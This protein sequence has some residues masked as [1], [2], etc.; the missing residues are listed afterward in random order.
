MGAAISNQVANQVIQTSYKISNAV[1]QNCSTV[2]NNNF[3]LGLTGG[4]QFNGD[5]FDVTQQNTINTSCVQNSTVKNT[6]QSQ[7]TAQ[8]TSQVNAAAQSLG[9]PSV[10]LANNIQNFAQ[11]TSEQITNR[12][13]QSCVN[14]STNNATINCANSSLNHTAFK[15]TQGNSSYDACANDADIQ[16]QFVAS[17]STLIQNNTSATEADTL[18][19]VIIIIFVFL[20]IGAIFFIRTLNGPMGWL[21]VGIVALVIIGLLVYAAFAYVDG[22]YPFKK[23]T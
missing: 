19:G 17:L 18:T 16:N 3:T 9:G 23:S 22:L 21:I 20:A 2:S 7:I 14:N 13:T 4:C 11:Q 1:I 6:M 5:T 8:I 12:F 10:T 15:F